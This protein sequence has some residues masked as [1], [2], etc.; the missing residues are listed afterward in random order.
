MLIELSE[1]KRR[2]LQDS[3]FW[4]QGH[5]LLF[6]FINNQ[7]ILERG[8]DSLII[9]I[10]IPLVSLDNLRSIVRPPIVT[11]VINILGIPVIFLSF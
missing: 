6:F 10:S 11:S 3:E 2:C 7:I 1:E 8:L 5:S 9:S 4:D